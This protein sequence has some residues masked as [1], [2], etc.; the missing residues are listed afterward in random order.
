M[1]YHIKHSSTNPEANIFHP[2]NDP[3]Q[4]SPWDNEHYDIISRPMDEKTRLFLE[5]L[6]NHYKNQ[7]TESTEYKQQGQSTTN[8]EQ[9]LYND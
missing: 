7:Q 9:D 6:Q 4:N 8:V 2:D 3:D 1:P 5:A